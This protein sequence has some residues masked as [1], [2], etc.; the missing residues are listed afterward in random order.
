MTATINSIYQIMASVPDPEVPVINIIELGVLRSVDIIDDRII[1]TIT[2]TYTGCPA[3]DMIQV[4]ILSV[5]Q[6]HGY[7]NVEI[8]TIIDPPWSTDWISE[9]G[10]TKLAEYGIAPPAQKT[11]DPSY[12][13]G[14][15]PTVTC[16]QCHSQNTKMISLFGSTACK[17]LYKCHDCL[18]PFDYFKCH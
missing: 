3:M 13:L 16:P 4:N 7:Q 5:M 2:P 18:E 10:R 14:I 9:S 1:I 12:L 6:D 11:T 17:S 8:K 15:M